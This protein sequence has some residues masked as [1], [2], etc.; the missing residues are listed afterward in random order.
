MHRRCRNWIHFAL[1][2]SLTIA[3]WADERHSG[4][5]DWRS[6]LSGS[7]PSALPGL[8]GEC[9]QERTGTQRCDYRDVLERYRLA[10]GSFGQATT[11]PIRV[12]AAIAPLVSS[13]VGLDDLVPARP[14]SALANQARPGTARPTPAARR[15]R[16]AAAG[17]PRPSARSSS[18]APR[19]RSS[20]APSRST[21]S[22]PTRRS[23]PTRCSNSRIRSMCR[24]AASAAAR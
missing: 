20:T 18:R 7:T 9:D 13:V 24:S 21:R 1:P 3:T 17:S 10:D 5:G 12:P 2:R 19:R 22:E 15:S 4:R 23:S 16:S 11:G 6:W 8:A 14:A